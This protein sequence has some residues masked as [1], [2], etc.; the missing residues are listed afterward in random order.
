MV[1]EVVLVLDEEDE[2]IED[3]ERVL[4]ADVTD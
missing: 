3:I 4:P 1:L 2:V